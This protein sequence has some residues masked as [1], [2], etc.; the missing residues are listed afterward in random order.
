MMLFE[1]FHQDVSARGQNVVACI[2]STSIAQKWK[3]LPVSCRKD[4]HIWFNHVIV[5][6]VKTSIFKAAD[7][8]H[9][10]AKNTNR[11]AQC[12]EDAV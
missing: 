9:Q 1:D 7:E 12:H 11:Q 2:I 4:D 6:T 10:A 8:R 5:H 3:L